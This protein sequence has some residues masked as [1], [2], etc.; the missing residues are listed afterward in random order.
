LFI[1]VFSFS[2]TK[3]D[4]EFDIYNYKP[5]KQDRLILELN[6][7][8]LLGLPENVTYKP[9]SGGVN[10]MLFF[11]YPLKNSRFSFAWGAGISSHNIHGKIKLNYKID[12][13]SGNINFTSLEERTEPYTRNR[14]GL[15]IVELPVELRFR[16]RTKYQ[17]KAMLG[18]KIGYVAQSFKK[19]FDKDGKNKSY[20]IYGI[21]PIRYGVNLRLGWEQVHLTCF[22]ALSEV[23]EK[24]KGS[25]GIIPFSIGI[26][27]T[28]RISL[29]SGSNPKQS[30]E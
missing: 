30:T 6:H 28:P 2:Q 25:V 24:D 10:F 27:Y 3:N 23:F 16:T 18:F 19:T 29:G 26:A 14:I 11:D 13:I 4:S 17:F 9:T 12:S 5:R 7:T 1:C 20:D 8:G 22:Y 21:N 15:K